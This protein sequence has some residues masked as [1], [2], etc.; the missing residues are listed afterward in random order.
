MNIGEHKESRLVPTQSAA[1]ARIGTN[2]LTARARTDL[3]IKEEA[4]E[5]LRKGL[6]LQE[7]APADPWS[8]GPINPYAIRR[9]LAEKLET[10][11]PAYIQQVLAGTPPDVAAKNLRMTPDDQEMAHVAH[12]FMPDTLDRVARG[13]TRGQGDRQSDIGAVSSNTP[14]I[15][16]P[17]GM[18]SGVL[19]Q[20]TIE[21]SVQFALEL[22]K[23]AQNEE[24]KLEQLKKRES[25]LKEAFQCFE[26]GHELAPTNPELLCR[27]ADAYYWGCGVQESEKRALALYQRAARL[28]S[29]EA[30]E[31]IDQA[32]D[33]G[34]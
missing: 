16:S 26:K 12:F 19:T 8:R 28:G 32:N 24:G 34:E 23:L 9:T 1:L 4:A 30:Q 6:E 33:Q 11:I 18:D 2:S 5:W 17:A 29:A 21:K 15:P 10:T 13:S 22:E 31:A 14:A 7:A 20:A 3:R 25:V 27:L